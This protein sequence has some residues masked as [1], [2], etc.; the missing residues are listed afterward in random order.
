[1]QMDEERLQAAASY[2]LTG[3]GSGM[4]SRGGYLVYSWGDQGLRYDLKSST[5]SIAGTALALALTDNLL[6]LFDAAQQHLPIIGIPPAENSATGWLDDI[7]I[8]HLATH[9]AGFA[10]TGG[11]GSLIFAPGTQWSYSDGGANW[12]ADVLTEVYREDLN[13]LLFRRVFSRLG[14]SSADLVWRSNFYREDTLDG[15]KR[16]EFGSGIKADVNALGRVGYLYLREGNWEG[17]QIL[18]A[19]VVSDLRQPY[20]PFTSLPVIDRPIDPNAS[21]HYGLLWWTNADGSLPGVPADAYWSWGLLDSLV[22]IIPSLDLVVVRAGPRGLL[23]SNV[24]GDYARLGPFIGPIVQS[25]S[26]LTVPLVVGSTLSQSTAAITA[27]G[28]SLGAVIRQADPNVPE[29]IVLSQVPSEGTLVNGG[30]AVELTVSGESGPTFSLRPSTLSFGNQ[31]LGKNSATL[32]VTLENT[33][34]GD[35]GPWTIGL[36]GANAADFIQTH[37]CPTSLASGEQCSIDVSFKPSATG[38]KSAT[39]SVATDL[40]GTQSV[41]LSG[42][43]IRATYSVSPAAINFGSVQKKTL[44]AAASIT[45]TNTNVVPLPL[46][47]IALGGSNPKQF[48]QTNDCSAEI[49]AGASCT[50][51]VVFKP[52]TVGSKSAKLTITPGGGAAKKSVSLSGTGSQ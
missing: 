8:I 31:V 42:V 45:V 23:E 13:S 26:G 12:L 22:V 44:S 9:T 21:R 16:R 14:I 48:G 28:L 4:V 49:A 47:S 39:L 32:S 5:K 20:P 30:T 7:Q 41:S 52:T 29:G 6:S 43:G 24:T 50:I 18:S 35:L 19:T 51:S 27:S 15:V 1:M 2:A 36:S 33:G 11:Y 3:G 37:S 10:K 17:E 38:S 40:A 34:A 46:M 25:V